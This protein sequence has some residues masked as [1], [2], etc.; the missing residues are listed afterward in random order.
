MVEGREGERKRP[1]STVQRREKEP[2]TLVCK[3][4]AGEEDGAQYH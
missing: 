1:K 2:T 3:T 4:I